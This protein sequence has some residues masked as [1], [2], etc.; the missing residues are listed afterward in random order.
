[1]MKTAGALCAL[2]YGADA[3]RSRVR[4]NGPFVGE[5]ADAD[6]IHREDSSTFRATAT[7]SLGNKYASLKS[8]SQGGNRKSYETELWESVFGKT[9]QELKLEK[10]VEKAQ[11]KNKTLKKRLRQ[12]AQMYAFPTESD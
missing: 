1:M 10:A 5:Y 8:T 2:M 6:V 3:L 7:K 9:E 12:D 4:D 11:R